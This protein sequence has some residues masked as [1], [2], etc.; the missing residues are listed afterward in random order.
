MIKTY[1]AKTNVS[2]NVVLPT[3]KKSTHISF[4]PLSDGSST[5]TTDNEELQYAIEHNYRFN[6]L[7]FLLSKPEYTIEAPKPVAPKEDVAEKAENP[8]ESSRKLVM[9]VSDIASAK[10]YLAETFGIS[11]TSLRSKAAILAQAE[12]HGIIFEGL[13]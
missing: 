3:S 8:K 10:D 9:S 4:V 5:F 2:I 1:K 6:S 12:V 7:F 13:E 11:R